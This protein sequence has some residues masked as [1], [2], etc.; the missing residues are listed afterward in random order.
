MLFVGE[1]AWPGRLGQYELGGL[2]WTVDEAAANPRRDW[3]AIARLRF[4]GPVVAYPSHDAFVDLEQGLSRAELLDCRLELTIEYDGDSFGTI[5]GAVDVAGQTLQLST[6]GVCER[7][8]R[9]DLAASRGGRVALTS[10]LD[11]PLHVDVDLSGDSSFVSGESNDVTDWLDAFDLRAPS[12]ERFH[13]EATLRV[14]V[15]RPQPDGSAIKVT[16]G[17]VAAGIPGALSK[18]IRGVFE[19][20]ERI[21]KAP[22]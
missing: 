17:V 1:G 16:F 9:A 6:T 15:Y 19:T 11:V 14:P 22:C 7:G 4:E 13:A 2:R 21:D 12:G 5:E 20:V 8:S 18:E 10:G 3:P